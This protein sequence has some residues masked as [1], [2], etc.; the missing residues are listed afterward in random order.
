[1]EKETLI[2]NLKAKVGEN[3]FGILS[4]RTLDSIVDPILPMFAD[5][6]KITDDTY[7]L[8]VNMLRSFIGQY[9]HDLAEGIKSGKTAWE[10]EQAS[11]REKAVSDAV[12]KARSEWESAASV[13]PAEEKPQ[14]TAP[15]QVSAEEI[16]R[17]VIASLTAKDGAL[18][19]LNSTLSS[20]M[21]GY[22]QQQRQAQVSDI[23]GMLHSYLTEELG[24][25]RDAVVSLAI[26]ETPVPENPD[27]ERL[28][29]TVKQRY[30]ARYKDF[31]G[32]MPAGGRAGAF[33]GETDSAAEF[34]AFI[35]E[36]EQQA[37]NQARDAETIR[38]MM[39]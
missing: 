32:D 33:G 29:E 13:K 15:A 39:M 3:D 35:R 26:N 38:S 28:K 20:F 1:M 37:Q 25:D 17:Q 21:E 16:T 30:E 19:Q 12:A 9:R 2:Q 5:D 11:Q 27:I 18:G 4:Q 8:P 7:T 36:R 24:A 14:E 34:T 6:E 31:Y 10:A 23:R 22:K